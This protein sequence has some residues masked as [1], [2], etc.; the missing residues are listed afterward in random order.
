[1][2]HWLLKIKPIK[3]YYFLLISLLFA[4]SIQAQKFNGGLIA[5]FSASQVAVHSRVNPRV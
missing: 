2:Y 4:F 1:M 3:K 5:G